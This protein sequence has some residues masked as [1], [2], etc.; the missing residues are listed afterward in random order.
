MAE[1]KLI[2]RRLLFHK[3]GDPLLD[4][5][6]YVLTALTEEVSCLIV[7]VFIGYR[8]N[9]KVFVRDFESYEQEEAIE[10]A[11]DFHRTLLTQ[12]EQLRSAGDN[13]EALRKIVKTE[14][15]RMADK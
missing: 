7:W 13:A 8:P 2:Y 9:R 1:P 14:L 12:I 4:N 11:V 10:F 15:E 5:G 6:V 3:P